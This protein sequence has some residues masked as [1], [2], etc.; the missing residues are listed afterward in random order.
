MENLLTLNMLWLLDKVFLLWIYMIPMYL[1]PIQVPKGALIRTHRIII[2]FF[3]KT[4][5]GWRMSSLLLESHLRAFCWYSRAFLVSAEARVVYST[6]LST[7]A[8]I[9]RYC[10][11]LLVRFQQLKEMTSEENLWQS[12]PIDNLPLL[13]NKHC[14]VHEHLV[15]LLD[16]RLQLHEHLVPDDQGSRNLGWNINLSN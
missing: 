9:L 16:R 2:I 14:H 10:D 7:W 11:Q 5:I 8:S 3:L 12:I 13:L 1:R 6:A 4:E 15:E